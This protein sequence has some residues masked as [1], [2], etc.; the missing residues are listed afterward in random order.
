MKKPD[1]EKDEPRPRR[2]AARNVSK[3]AYIEEE[4]NNFESPQQ[5]EEEDT[6]D[7]RKE[8]KKKRGRG[9]PPKVPR[10]KIKMIGRSRDSDSPIFCAQTMGEVIN[11]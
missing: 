6:G 3:Q 7:E 10:M 9:R 4:P 5:S 11:N 8:V 1:E 2:R